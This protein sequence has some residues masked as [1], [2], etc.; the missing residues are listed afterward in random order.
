[1]TE[2]CEPRDKAE[3]QARID[4]SWTA[5]QRFIDETEPA[6]LTEPRDAEGWSAKDHLSHIAVWE[7]S[8]IS[9]LQSRPRHEGL[10]VDE[11]T[12]LNLEEDTINAVMQRQTKDHSLDDVLTDLQAT[13]EQLIGMIA[14]LSD[15]DLRRT[16]SSFLPDEPGNED[17]SP[18]LD[19][20]IGNTYEHFD[21]H[22]TWM[23]TLAERKR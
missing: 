21:A 5:L 23:E 2:Q 3:L 16:Y 15:E 10:G 8:M 4:T 6:R 9:L 18:I 20:L 14:D 11:A 13:H 22:R 1:M 12:Y 7:R 17:G 19:R